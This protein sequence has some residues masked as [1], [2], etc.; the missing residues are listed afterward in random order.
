MSACRVGTH[1]SAAATVLHKSGQ[2][3]VSLEAWLEQHPEAL[4]STLAH[5]RPVGQPQGRLP[6]LMKVRRVQLAHCLKQYSVLLLR[7]DWSVGQACYHSQWCLSFG[8]CL[9]PAFLYC[10]VVNPYL[11]ADC[12]VPHAAKGCPS[13]GG[14]QH[15]YTSMSVACIPCRSR[16]CAG[17][18]CPLPQ[19]LSIDRA[20]P[21]QA[22]PT[23]STAHSLHQQDPQVSPQCCTEQREL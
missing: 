3:G 1:P 19:V 13:D 4:G 22:H 6:F 15:K 12:F 5:L 11:Q 14:V 7:H 9:Q 21:L 18:S 23:S 16:R 20:L 17:V 8:I 10:E 2:P